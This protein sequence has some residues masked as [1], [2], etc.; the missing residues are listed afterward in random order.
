VI[1]AVKFQWMRDVVE[2][3][4]N[5]IMTAV[6]AVVSFF[7]AYLLPIFSLLYNLW[8]LQIQLV[9]IAIEL[10]IGAAMKVWSYIDGPLSAVWNALKAAAEPILK[11]LVGPIDAIKAAF[12]GVLDMVKSVIDWIGKIKI[13]D[14]GGLVSKLNPF[15]KSAPAPA[16]ASYPTLAGLG[17]RTSPRAPA[18]SSAAPGPTI[19]IQGALDPAAVARQ[20]RAILRD[21][22]RRRRGV[23]I[24]A[25]A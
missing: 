10:I 5:A 14:L 13:P 9:I 21:D 20:V 24:G 3:V 4:F 1:L 11:A 6:D 25:T 12:S 15:D 2:T 7:K 16:V 18:P 22:S 23:I 17:L 8:K 19:V